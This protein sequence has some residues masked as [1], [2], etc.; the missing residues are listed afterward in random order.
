MKVSYYFV[1]ERKLVQL[2]LFERIPAGIASCSPTHT[3]CIISAPQLTGS[4]TCQCDHFN[5]HHPLKFRT[6]RP[7]TWHIPCNCTEL[8]ER[9]LASP[10]PLP[11]AHTPHTPPPPAQTPK[12]F[13]IA[14]ALPLLFTSCLRWHHATLGGCRCPHCPGCS[15]NGGR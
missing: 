4:A 13:T 5:S 15:A 10:S 2:A 7:L 9:C 1:C 3:F 11:L 6:L 14:A 8:P 12:S